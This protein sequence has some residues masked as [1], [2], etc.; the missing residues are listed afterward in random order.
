MIVGI[1]VDI[2]EPARIARAM[3]NPRFAER[4]YTPRERERIAQAGAQS[5]Q[6]AAGI[7][8]AKEAAV[9]ALGCGFDGVGL[10]D[11][12]VVSAASGQPGLEL[13]G[14]AAAR[15]S[16][17]GGVRAQLSI[18]HIESAAVAFVVIEG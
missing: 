4:I 18:S 15:L 9:K 14:G 11:V 10:H 7:F 6:R 16:A 13:R 5:A 2:I 12:E 3:A 17:L 8:A 1:G